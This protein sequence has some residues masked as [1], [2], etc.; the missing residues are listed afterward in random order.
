MNDKTKKS[1]YGPIQHGADFLE[2]YLGATTAMIRITQKIQ[3]AY[4]IRRVDPK[5][6]PPESGSEATRMAED[7]TRNWLYRQRA[8]SNLARGQGQ[9]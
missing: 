7:V 4:E 6:W 1:L 5:R 3:A 2:A 8:R 9:R